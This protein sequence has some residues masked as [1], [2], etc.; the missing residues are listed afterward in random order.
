VACGVED[1]ENVQLPTADAADNCAAPIASLTRAT[2]ECV[3]AKRFGFRGFSFT[4]QYYPVFHSVQRNSHHLKISYVR[5]RWGCDILYWSRLCCSTI[6]VDSDDL[7]RIRVAQIIH[8][9]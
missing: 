7:H 4:G 5:S 6:D 3:S 8:D 2:R 1:V 9:H